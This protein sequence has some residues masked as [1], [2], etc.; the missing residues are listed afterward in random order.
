MEEIK[1][2]LVRVLYKS[3]HHEDFWV[4]NFKVGREF[5]S[6]TLEWEAYEGKAPIMIGVDDIAAIWQL[7]SKLIPS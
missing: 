4:K 3:G 2:F 1:I 6:T 5:G 7:D